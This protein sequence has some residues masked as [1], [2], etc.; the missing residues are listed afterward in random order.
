MC[1]EFSHENCLCHPKIC[2]QLFKLQV[3]SGEFEAESAP[4]ELGV[5]GRYLFS[6]CTTLQTWYFLLLCFPHSLNVIC[7]NF[8]INLI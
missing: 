7:T 6:R 8:L 4:E 1:G 2:S 5:L 3:C